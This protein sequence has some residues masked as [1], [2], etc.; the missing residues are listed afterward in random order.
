MVKEFHLDLQNEYVGFA[1]QRGMNTLRNILRDKSE[2]INSNM[3]KHY[4]TEVIEC[5]LALHTTEIQGCRYAWMDIK[6]ENFIIVPGIVNRVVGIDLD[7]AMPLNH[8]VPWDHESVTWTN[9][10]PEIAYPLQ[11]KQK[12]D[13]QLPTGEQFDA[14]SLGIT[15]LHI[16]KDEALVI[17]ENE[18]DVR[19]NLMALKQT[20]VDA[21]ID[22]V[23]GCKDRH[24]EVLKRMLRVDL[25]ERTHTIQEIFNILDEGTNQ[26]KNQAVIE[27]SQ[28][29]QKEVMNKLSSIEGNLHEAKGEIQDTIFTAMANHSIN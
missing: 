6:L 25:T 24:K 28:N 21:F 10:P 26:K 1:M 22:A 7:Q 29:S 17:G 2:E 16:L 27:H 9:T 5:V 8:R 15:I 13:F 14:W 3:R 18:N 4:V 23:K 20:E 11:T 19:K 12:A